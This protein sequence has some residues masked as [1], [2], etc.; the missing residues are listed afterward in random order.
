MQ[1]IKMLALIMAVFMGVACSLRRLD[2]VRLDA[3]EECR[4]DML[5]HHL[6]PELVVR[7]VMSLAPQRQALVPFRL[8][9]LGVA[10]ELV[11]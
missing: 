6:S 10:A 7:E 4:N 9:R 2:G 5:I 11:R 1:P 3:L 8:L